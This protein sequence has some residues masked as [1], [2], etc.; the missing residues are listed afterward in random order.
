[1]ININKNTWRRA[2]LAL[3]AGGLGLLMP[4]TAY[5]SSQSFNLLRG[6]AQQG[7]IVSLT[8]NT[9][10]VEPANDKNVKSLVGVISTDEN[11]IDQ[12]AGQINVKTDGA[13]S[14]IVSTL[15]GD[16]SV[17]DR[18]TASPLEGVGTKANSSAWIVGT[19]Q[20]S[21]DSST[22]GA[23]NTEI[24]DSNGNKHTVFV[25]SIPI[26]VKVTYYNSSNTS[27]ATISKQANNPLQQVADSFAGKHVST[28]ALILSFIILLIGL[29]TAGVVITSAVKGGLDAI[30]RQ[31]LSKRFISR[32]V[33]RAI[34]IAVGI[35][36]F[37]LVASAL[38]L[39]LL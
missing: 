26:L 2:L 30:S 14:A 34:G 20:A 24:T 39:R 28:A 35:L 32:G 27:V 22:K 37:V 7:I 3:V 12:Q 13:T 16:I 11:S 5:A 6:Q 17:G 4:A 10:F 23:T 18:V 36:V 25:A 33:W 31:P 21:L 15:N 29:F 38:I 1:M 19:A 8:P 9:G